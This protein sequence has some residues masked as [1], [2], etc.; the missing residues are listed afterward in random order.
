MHL[1]EIKLGRKNTI[2]SCAD[3]DVGRNCNI[4]NKH[5]R[6]PPPLRFQPRA[7][8]RNRGMVN[9]INVLELSFSLRSMV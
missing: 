4:L 8:I 2:Q 3:V 1:Y 5:L 9:A 6:N 7:L